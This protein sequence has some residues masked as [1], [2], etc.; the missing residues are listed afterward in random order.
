MVLNDGSVQ[1]DLI[2]IC[3]QNAIKKDMNK[4]L[5]QVYMCIPI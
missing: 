3:I 5:L 2:F 1:Q 4:V